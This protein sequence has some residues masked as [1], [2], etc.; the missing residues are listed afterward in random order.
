[1]IEKRATMTSPQYG[2]APSIR[3][4]ID[5]AAAT[6]RAAEN[7]A[8]ARIADEIERDGNPFA[9]VIADRIRSRLKQGIGE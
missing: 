3:Q 2:L 6:A 7:E 5:D 4:M 8:C 1:M 9:A